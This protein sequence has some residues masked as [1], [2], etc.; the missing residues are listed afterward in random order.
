MVFGIIVLVFAR[1]V[2]LIVA[3]L[4]ITTPFIIFWMFGLS[5]FML[6]G[7]YSCWLVLRAVRGGSSG[8]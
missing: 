7:G 4:D 6:S 2:S 3:M 8:E 5:A 1:D